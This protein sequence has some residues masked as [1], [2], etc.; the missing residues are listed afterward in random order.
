M[1]QVESRIPM[2][3]REAV[4]T[5][6]AWLQDE[7]REAGEL[8]EQWARRKKYRYEGEHKLAEERYQEQ[9][10]F[11]K[12]VDYLRRKKFIK[13]KKTERGLLLELS[14]EG[15]AELMRRLVR[16]RPLLPGNQVCLVMYDVPT[17]GNL[18]RDALRY[19]LKRIGLT[20]VQ[21]SVW[22]TDKD[23]VNEVLEFV[24]SSQITKWV[25]VYL[26]KKQ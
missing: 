21:Q 13:T 24:R 12:R 2:K 23:V 10:A 4:T 17:D 16:E 8:F 11:Q 1:N 22:S 5:V 25:E 20:Q 19:F 26:A 9:R 18:G 14:N 6:L 7:A 15:Q 3:G